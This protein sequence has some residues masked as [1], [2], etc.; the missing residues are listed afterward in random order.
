MLKQLLAPQLVGVYVLAGV[1]FTCISAV[2]SVFESRAAR[3]PL[4]VPRPLQRANVAGSGV[5][6]EPCGLG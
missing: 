1:L 2:A 3:R 6:N 5:P 4:D